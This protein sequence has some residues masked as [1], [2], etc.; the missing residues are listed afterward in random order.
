MSAERIDAGNNRI[1]IFKSK[2][3]YKTLLKV[4]FV[5][6]IAIAGGI[7]V[8]NVL[9]PEVQSDISLANVEALANGES[10]GT[11]TWMCE[12]TTDNCYAKCGICGTTI[13]PSKGRISGYHTC[14][15]GK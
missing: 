2:N 11:T 10:S 12:D 3:I 13:G 8:F 5:V 15:I 4:A 6:A 14:S 1:L 9:P 7:S